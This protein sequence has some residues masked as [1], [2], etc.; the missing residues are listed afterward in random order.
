MWKGDHVTYNII[1]RDVNP[2]LYIRIGNFK[3]ES[4]RKYLV[5]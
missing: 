5:C 3:K 1:T 2:R 4:T